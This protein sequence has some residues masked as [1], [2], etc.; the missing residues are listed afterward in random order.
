MSI[1]ID[2][3]GRLVVPKSVR[4]AMGLRPGIPVDVTFVDGHIEIEYAP[5]R[6]K[7]DTSAELPR[8]I[9]DGDVESID[10]EIVRSVLDST[11]R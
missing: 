4:D 3:A 8:L 2:A 9:P 5:I 6:A 11:R 7:I 10:D 1:T